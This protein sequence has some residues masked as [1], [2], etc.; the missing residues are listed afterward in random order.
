MHLLDYHR[1]TLCPEV[2]QGD[3]M[4]LTARAKA[5][6][7][8]QV[9]RRF[10]RAVGVYFVGDLVGHYYD[11][12]T[13]LDI[14]VQVPSALQQRYRD[15]ASVVSGY[16]LKNS[17]HPVFFHIV[18]DNVSRS[19]LTGN[20]GTLYDPIQGSWLGKH[21]ADVSELLHPRSLL[22][23]IQWKLYRVKNQQEPFP[24]KWPVVQ[25]AFSKL[26]SNDRDWILRKLQGRVNA[27]ESNLGNVV[28]RY[29]SPELGRKVAALERALDEGQVFHG[30]VGHIVASTGLPD[31]VRDALLNRFRYEDLL[32][33]LA[34]LEERL[35][36]EEDRDKIQDETRIILS[37]V[38]EAG[39]QLSHRATHLIDRLISEAGDYGDAPKVASA[40]IDRVLRNSRFLNT[41]GRRRRVAANLFLS[42]N[43]NGET[44]V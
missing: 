2:W 11:D 40:I 8:D 33:R 5:H 35:K 6:L 37:S 10:P 20:F 21:T 29:N 32:F 9:D 3:E 19:N 43:R 24:Y 28:A 34:S 15:E 16:N 26:G 42:Y 25:A 14:I 41:P 17:D 12:T 27:L 1:R 18:P 22:Q 39:D 36:M 13:P 38:G 30:E 44:D 23:R 7:R 4:T 31:R